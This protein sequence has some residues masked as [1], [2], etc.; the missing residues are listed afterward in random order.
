MSGGKEVSAPDPWWTWP[1]RVLGVL[2]IASGLVGPVAW[3]YQQNVAAVP[4][5][6]VLAAGSVSAQPERPVL[7]PKMLHLPPGDF[8]LGS[9]DFGNAKPVRIV[10]ITRAFALSETEVTQAQY[11]AVMGN[12]PSGH[13]DTPDSA[14]HP[15]EA[16][17]WFD[18]VKYCNRLSELEGRKPCYTVQTEEG[19]HGAKFERVEWPDASCTAYRLPTEAEWEYAARADQPYQYA[20]SD[21]LDRVAWHNGNSSDT[22][23]PVAQKAPNAWFLHDMSGNVWEWVWDRYSDSYLGAETQD[24]RGARTGGFRVQRGGSFLSDASRARVALRR[25]NM[26]SSRDRDV[27]FRLARSLP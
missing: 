8:R 12:N 6:R 26:T 10:H 7:R 24:P 13:K 1:T 16:V 3:L 2:L 9:E 19:E 18:A 22:T 27:G 23:H 17:S 25:F 4:K 5:Q 15:V 11:Q 20:G 21:D 14:Q